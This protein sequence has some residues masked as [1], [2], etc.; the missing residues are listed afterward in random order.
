MTGEYESTIEELTAQMGQ[1][2]EIQRE[3]SLMEEELK[4][5]AA[6][7]GRLQLEKSQMEKEIASQKTELEQTKKDA[8]ALEVLF[9]ARKKLMR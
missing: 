8:K 3:R 9:Y 2:R 7:I 4:T 6:S 5:L 1:L